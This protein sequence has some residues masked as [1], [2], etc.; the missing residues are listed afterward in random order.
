MSSFVDECRKEWS[1][2]GVPEAVANEM[3]ADLQADLAEAEADGLS[4]EAVLGNGF[5]DP[6]SFAASWATARGV[7]NPRPPA[8]ASDRL[9]SWNLIAG[10]LI[11]VTAAFIAFVGFAILV[12]HSVRRSVSVVAPALRPDFKRPIPGAF[13]G[14]QR[15][16]TAHAGPALAAVGGLLIVAGLAVL[17]VTLWLWRR[18]TRKRSSAFD[19]DVGLPSYF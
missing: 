8:R 11:C 19:H 15:V 10:G 13:V 7:V 6:K 18:S 5:F 14:P 3:A 1:R 12:G 2:L 16:L 9:R 17:G 4:P